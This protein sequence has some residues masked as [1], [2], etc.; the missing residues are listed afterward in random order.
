MPKQ[1]IKI[2]SRKSRLAVI[3]A[4]MVINQIKRYHQNYDVELITMET[5][6]DKILDQPLDLIGG[7]GLFAGELE[8]ALI[9]GTIDLSVHS[10]KDMPEMIPED[11]P[12]LAF[13]KREDPR[14]ALLLPDGVE[15]Q[16]LEGLDISIPVGCSSARRKI[17]LLEL[18]QDLIIAPV[19]GNVP[20][21]IKKMDD[22][23]YNTLVLALA[24]L[25]RLGIQNRASKIFSEQE[26][27]PAAGQGIIAVQGRKDF[28]SDILTC[29]DNAH[30][31]IAAFAERAVIAG[32]QCGCSSPAAA[33]CKVSGNEIQISALYAD[34]QTGQ[35]VTG[36]IYGERSE[37][38][39]LAEKLASNLLKAVAGYE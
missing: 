10:L 12:I 14:D 3:Q 17:Q 16:G 18:R 37:A 21:R 20:T 27:L 38:L 30:S 7:K 31:R 35:K 5:S 25:K 4:E 34:E 22:G 36:N 9:K 13:S 39:H 1:K 33:Y 8:Q 23:Q 28:D 2:G 11:L 15:F 19:R 29:F 24:G 32:L 26:I 6:G